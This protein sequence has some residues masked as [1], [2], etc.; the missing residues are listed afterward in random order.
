[1]TITEKPHLVLWGA[2][3][4]RT[5]R[6]HWVL[7]ELGLDYERRPIGARTGPEDD[8]NADTTLWKTRNG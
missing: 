1:M 4:A 7:H 2:G 3:T 6:A 8:N 5:M